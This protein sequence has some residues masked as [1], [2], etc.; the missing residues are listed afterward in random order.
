MQR[1]IFIT[2][3]STGLG[4]ARDKLFQAKG[5]NVIA[6]MRNPKKETELTQL[7]DV[8][9]LELDVTNIEQIKSVVETRI[10][11]YSIDFVFNNA[12]YG[13]IAPLESLSDEQIVKQIETNLLGVIRV[14]N[15]LFLI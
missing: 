4:K 7:F 12:G 14:T 13:F 9:I 11:M 3:A 2:G 1:T 15:D 8:F 6:T 10:S 5:W